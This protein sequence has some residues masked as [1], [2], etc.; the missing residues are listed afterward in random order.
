[1]MIVSACLVGVNCK[2]NGGNNDNDKVK[3]FLKDKQYIIICPEQLGGLTTPRKP[4]EINQAGGKEVLIGNSK[5]ISCENKDVTE[6]FVKGAKESLNIAKIFNC[7]Q[8]LLKEGS[9]SCGC[10]LI[11]DGTFTGKKI[12]GMGVTAALFNENNIEVFSE[13]EL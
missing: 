10:N 8:A 12:S 11:Y 13:K 9:P 6:N 4:S 5:V 2:Y 1:M 3:E 7:K